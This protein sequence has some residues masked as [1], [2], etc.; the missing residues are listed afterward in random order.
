[1]V[2]RASILAL[3]SPGPQHR[4]HRARR[5]QHLRLGGKLREHANVRAAVVARI[6][7]GLGLERPQ[8]ILARRA[9]IV[10]GG[11]PKARRGHECHVDC[12]DHPRLVGHPKGRR[13]LAP[14]PAP[15]GARGLLLRCDRR[16]LADAL[17][18]VTD[19]GRK[20]QAGVRRERRARVTAESGD[21][22]KE[23][24]DGLV[25]GTR[26]EP[27][28]EHLVESEEGVLLEKQRLRATPP[29]APPVRAASGCAHSPLP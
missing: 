4:E 7:L 24:V 26:V 18:D 5:I 14:H 16:E 12:D 21:A 2:D 27:N 29:A 13:Q 20:R 22:P 28:G 8:H 11:L 15:K 3:R 19:G 25:A 17:D 1:M 10:D 23:G 6:R 9:H